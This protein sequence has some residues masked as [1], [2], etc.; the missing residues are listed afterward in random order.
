VRLAAH[1]A[2]GALILRFVFPRADAPRRRAWIEWWAAKLLAILNVH[3]RVAGAPPDGARA[4]MI[5]ANHVSWIDIFVVQSVRTTRF[6]AKSEI[7]DW[8][9]AGWI[10]ER[11][12]TVFLRRGHRRDAARIN[13]RV[14]EALAAGDCV[15]IFPEGTTTEGD[16]LLKFHALLFES[17]IAHG[18]I[19]QPA[20]IVY[21][22]PDG[23]PCPEVAYAGE[24]TFMESVGRIIGRKRIVARLAFADPIETTGCTRREVSQR[25]RERVASLLGFSP[26]TPPGTCADR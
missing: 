20:A 3:T 26:D 24:T 17:A 19:V 13:E 6:V 12:G 11:A 14:H 16:R 9:I 4:A 7:R 18:A 22:T 8:P 5:A 21:E 2:A 25:A 15:G 23:A 10:A 1:A